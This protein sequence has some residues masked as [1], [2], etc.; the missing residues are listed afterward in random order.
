[1]TLV[2]GYTGVV[3]GGKAGNDEQECP[4]MDGDGEEETRAHHLL[5]AQSTS[6]NRFRR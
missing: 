2:S 4:I 6:T 3:V 5:S 1:M